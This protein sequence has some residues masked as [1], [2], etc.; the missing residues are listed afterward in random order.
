[1]L[2]L[3]LKRGMNFDHHVSTPGKDLAQEK[4]FK[5]IKDAGFDHVRLPFEFSL[6]KP[7]I[8]P[9]GEYYGRIKETAQ[10]ALDAGLYVIV[11]VH[12]FEG[13]QCDPNGMKRQLYRLWSGLSEA[14]RDMDDRVIFE[15][16]NEPDGAFNYEILNE[17]QNE[18]ISII[19]K[20]N[21]K[22]LIAAACAHCN[23]I[24]NLCNLVLP[25]NDENIFVT[26]HEYTPMRF[27]HQG[28]D[29]MAGDWP[30]GITWGTQEDKELLKERFDMAAEWGKAHNRRLH[31]GE[32]GAIK[33]AS[34]G[35]RL[36]WTDYVIRLCE[37]RN[38]AWSY[39][40]LSYVYAAYNL[41]TDEW[42]DDFL[43][44]FRNP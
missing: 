16:Y 37:E 28:A 25:E 43:K 14:L 44:I 40:E 19:R 2:D 15:I 42:N 5:L 41:E 9:C 10:M 17:V 18:I 29:W 32:F 21:P 35:D 38:I 4:Y 11:D 8:F 26:I 36:A 13:M 3:K 22:R 33:M 7:G 20:T 6:T 34:L 24:E 1:M 31:L 23:T 39:W 27:T 30:T 12:P